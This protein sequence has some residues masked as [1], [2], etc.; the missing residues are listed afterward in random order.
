MLLTL[1]C[2]AATLGCLNLYIG[3]AYLPASHSEYRLRAPLHIVLGSFTSLVA[4]V[5]S[6]C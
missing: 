4:L 3:F 6:V 2:L 1:I 5:A